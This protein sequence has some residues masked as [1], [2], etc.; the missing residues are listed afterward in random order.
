[1]CKSKRE[2]LKG[3]VQEERKPGKQVQEDKSKNKNK[4]QSLKVLRALRIRELVLL[5]KLCTLKVLQVKVRP[6][7]KMKSFKSFPRSP[8][9]RTTVWFPPTADPK[10]W[11]GIKSHTNL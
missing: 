2:E 5:K 7:I 3:K 10:E 6:E 4:L 9:T 8:P 1:M 11:A